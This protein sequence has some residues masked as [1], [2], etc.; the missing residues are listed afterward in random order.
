MSLMSISSALPKHLKPPPRKGVRPRARR[1]RRIVLQRRSRQLRIVARGDHG[2]DLKWCLFGGG[3]FAADSGSG[4]IFFLRSMRWGI[5]F[6]QLDELTW[7]YFYE[8][9]GAAPAW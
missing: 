7:P 3:R 6:I 1:A 8:D 4:I 2:A 5:D 9:W